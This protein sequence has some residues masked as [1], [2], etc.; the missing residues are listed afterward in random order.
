M[1]ISKISIMNTANNEFHN[2]RM[3]ITYP[4]GI[5]HQGKKDMMEW[6][7]YLGITDWN[8]S[9]LSVHD[10][11][12]DE[13]WWAFWSEQQGASLVEASDVEDFA[14]Y[15]WGAVP[16]KDFIDFGNFQ[17]GG[18]SVFDYHHSNL[19]SRVV[20][21]QQSV[22]DIAGQY[23]VIFC[24]GLLYHLRH[25]LLAVDRLSAACR[26]VLIMETFVDQRG[27]EYQ[28]RNN[29][30]RT[31]ELGPVSNWT[32]ANTA[33][34]ASWLRNAGFDHVAFTKEPFPGNHR[35]IFV[36]AKGADWF[37]LFDR[38]NLTECDHDYWHRV[39]EATKYRSKQQYG[40]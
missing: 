22:Y 38:D 26:G 24:H 6:C 8:M 5:M 23:D 15:D 25:P 4:D 32:G 17:R 40:Q 21:R 27:D 39:F 20:V 12:T 30:Y 18:R 19:N 31:T 9:G 35:R 37:E 36:A 2:L 11:A 33:C 16:D 28:A 34:I 7:R 3:T 1:L 13:G 10:V 29:F 14:L